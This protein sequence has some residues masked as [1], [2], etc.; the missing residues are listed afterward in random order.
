MTYISQE[1]PVFSIKKAWYLISAV[2]KASA[3]QATASFKRDAPEPPQSATFEILPSNIPEY[4]N[5][6]AEKQL[7]DAL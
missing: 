6:L 2:T 5:P 1:Y 3:P 7:K 4:L